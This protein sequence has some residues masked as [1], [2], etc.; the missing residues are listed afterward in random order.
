MNRPLN[1]RSSPPEL[2]FYYDMKNSGEE[3]QIPLQLPDD[4][5]RAHGWKWQLTG[6]HVIRSLFLAC[7]PAYLLGCVVVVSVSFHCDCDSHSVSLCRQWLVA[8]SSL[9]FI[10]TSEVCLSDL[11]G[12]CDSWL[13]YEICRGWEFWNRLTFLFAKPISV[14]ARPFD[15]IDS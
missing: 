8:K 9:Y 2:N 4:E 7:L 12:I 1:T 14:S 13:W 6:C 11:V 3:L 15:T 10:G 5:L